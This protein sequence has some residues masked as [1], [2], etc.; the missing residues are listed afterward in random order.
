MK[1]S[2][3]KTIENVVI[4]D[5]DGKILLGEG[6]IEIKEIVDNLLAQGERK[7]LLNMTKVPHI[8]S[9]GLGEMIRC[10]TT[11]RKND[12]HFKLLSPNQRIKDLL[13]ITKLLNVFDC[14]DS[15]SAAI[16]SFS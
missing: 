3:R 5:V 8:D 2:T 7:I 1:F 15:E 16:E 13:H 9:A 10:F 12:G 6:D 14:Y 11:I 4:I